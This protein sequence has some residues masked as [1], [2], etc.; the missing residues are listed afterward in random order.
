MN[1]LL[2]P[3][4]LFSISVLFSLSAFGLELTYVKGLIH[5]QAYFEKHQ[6]VVSYAL[7][8]KNW[9]DLKGY[10]ILL[11][12]ITPAPDQ[13]DAHSC[14]IMSLT[15][16]AEFWLNRYNGKTEFVP[17]GELDLSERWWMNLSYSP[18]H[19][20]E[21]D[22][23][24]SDAIYLFNSTRAALNR[25]YPFVKGWHTENDFDVRPAKPSDT[26]ARY[27]VR[28][29]W[30][31]ETNSVKAPLLALPKF[32]RKILFK[33]KDE[34]PWAVGVTPQ[35][36]PQLVIET[37]EKYQAPVQVIYNHHGI[38]HS[39]V[40]VGFDENM[41]SYNCPFIK[42]TIRRYREEIKI[43]NEEKDE[44]RAS[45]FAEYLDELNKSLKKN[46]GCSP[47]GMF[48][49]RDSFYSD[50]SE[51]LYVY[52]PSN[53]STS[54]PYSKRVILREFDWLRNLANH[55]NVIYPVGHKPVTQ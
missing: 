14:M 12:Y 29:S 25:D 40:I 53:P 36:I 10:N 47:K 51:P 5:R 19:T 54:R 34:N 50:P 18:Q 21:A 45:M 3:F 43:S 31:D 37:M 7:A 27:G 4:Y 24:Y 17:N 23:W 30:Y 35:N 16:I 22:Y 20:K 33:D 39:V 52:D 2:R 8:P 15:G 46:G 42:E 41:S 55:I 49:V 26:N 44:D 13:E 38:W 9:K 32:E 11:P 1:T 6:P 28:Y 48:Y